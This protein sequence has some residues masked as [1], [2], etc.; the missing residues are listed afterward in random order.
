MKL[1]LKHIAVVI[2]T[3]YSLIIF[4]QNIQFTASAPKVVAV[5]ENFRLT[6]SINAKGANLSSP[7]IKD[8][9]IISGPNQSSSSSI[10]IINGQ[11]TQNVSYSY[12]YF[13]NATKEGKFTIEPAS[14]EV[15]G[16]EY[17]SNPIN[18]E[19]IKG[20]ANSHHQQ[21]YNN[22]NN[23]QN[24]QPNSSNDISTEDLFVRVNVDKNNLYV[25]EHLVATIKV[26]TK[27]D[28]AG[29]ESMKFPSYTGFWS[30]DIETPAQISL[31]RENYNGQ[32]Y[33]V[34]IIKKSILY[35]QQSGELNISPFELNC[36]VR[37]RV[38]SRQRGFF[39]D[40]FGSYQN[41]SKK[42]L[43]PKVTV[44]VKGLPENKHSSFK[45][46]VGNLNMESSIDK[47]E[48]KTN[49]AITIKVKI[50]GNGN[51]K[52][53]DSPKFNFPPDFE[54]Y[55]PKVTENI[56]NKESGSSGSKTFE[57]LIIPRHP[58]NYRIA[59]VEFTYFDTKSKEYKTLSTDEFNLSIGKGEGQSSTVMSSFSKEDVKYLGSDIRYIKTKN[60][61]I[62]KDN[63]YIKNSIYFILAYPILLFGFIFLVILRRKQIKENSN[64]ALVKNKKANKMAKKRLKK[65]SVFLKQNDKEKFYDEI[66]KAI[67]GYLSDKLLIP[68]ADLSKDRALSELSKFNIEL[69]IIEKLDKLIQDCE[70]ARYFPSKEEGHMENIYLDTINIIS[71]LDN[72][73]K[74]I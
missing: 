40:F 53:I 47:T 19:V 34:G 37:Q 73:I 32:I 16:K 12:T 67:W 13:L 57:Y 7:S 58:G 2:L 6:Y 30:Q 27:L 39:D 9:N 50:S 8:F 51:L 59:P 18:I 10:S 33:N 36:V 41:I 31:Q 35:P 22:N 52:L 48:A 24:T 69:E 23:Q 26:Y 21:Q 11:M 64:L 60:I 61:K 65:A 54:T 68:V 56:S 3:F 29:I 28:L 71:N 66:L 49:D 4:S 62:N 20:Q 70:F 15:E 5:G 25:G 74:S 17:K 1:I 42:L 44:N 38:Q 43:S 63:G 45:G 14:I 46:A 55:D 72:K